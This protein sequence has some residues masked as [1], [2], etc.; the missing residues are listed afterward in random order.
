MG[1]SD[2]LGLSYICKLDARMLRQGL[3]VPLQLLSR[4]RVLCSPG[5]VIT[6]K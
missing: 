3:S 1:G 5:L 6:P 4:K 2:W